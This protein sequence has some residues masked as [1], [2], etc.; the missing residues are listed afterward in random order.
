MGPFAHRV[1]VVLYSVQYATPRRC[2]L[3]IAPD[4]MVDAQCSAVLFL[5]KPSPRRDTRAVDLTVGHPRQQAIF[6]ALMLICP[7]LSH[8]RHGSL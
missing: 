8:C 3:Q 5:P 1:L 2:G 7:R 4:R 6:Q